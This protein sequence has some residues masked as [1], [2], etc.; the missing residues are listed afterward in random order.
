MVEPLQTRFRI[1]G[2][3]CASCAT[4]I[5]TAIR[6]MPGV[7]D[8]SI[9]VSAGTMTVEHDDTIDVEDMGKKVTGLGYP[10]KLIPAKSKAVPSAIEHVHGPGCSHDHDH[11]PDEHA[12][13]H[14]HGTTPHE[15]GFACMNKHGNETH[16]HDHTHENNGGHDHSATSQSSQR[17]IPDG[18]ARFHVGGMD[19]ASCA[20]KIDTA[21]RRIPGVEDVRAC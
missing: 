1:E 13:A 11:S 14:D 2:M 3:D 12:Q 10:T 6:R 19:C 4:K 7:Q 8:V 18:Q 16:S 21:G 17:P 15:H 5:D 9:S 20:S